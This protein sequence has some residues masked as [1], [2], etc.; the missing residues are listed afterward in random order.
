MQYQHDDAT[1][2]EMMTEMMTEMSAV[3]IMFAICE[4]FKHL[5]QSTLLYFIL[6]YCTLL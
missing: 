5:L 1:E 6:L 3:D 4:N 2:G